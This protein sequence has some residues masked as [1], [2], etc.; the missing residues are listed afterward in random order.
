MAGSPLLLSEVSCHNS[1]EYEAVPGSN[2]QWLVL[3]DFFCRTALLNV[4]IQYGRMTL[5]PDL[6]SWTVGWGIK[7]SA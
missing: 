5:Y 1:M 2:S 7:V 6:K 3:H 4:Q